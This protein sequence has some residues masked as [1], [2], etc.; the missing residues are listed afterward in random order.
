MKNKYNVLIVDD[1][2][3]N[4]YLITANLKKTGNCSAINCFTS[5]KKGLEYLQS[6]KNDNVRLPDIIFLDMNMPAMTGIDFINSYIKIPLP[7]K[8]IFAISNNFRPDEINFLQEKGIKTW[9][10]KP[11]T[12]EKLEEIFPQAT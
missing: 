11:I 5:A 7:T 6:L 10:K 9:I 4:N 3:I 1:D 8:L 12:R 2:E